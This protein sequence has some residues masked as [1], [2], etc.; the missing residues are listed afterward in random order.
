M[1]LCFQ[2]LGDRDER[3]NGQA[4]HPDLRE[5]GSVRDRVSKQEDAW[6]KCL[7]GTCGFH[8]PTTTHAGT[9][10]SKCVCMPMKYISETLDLIFVIVEMF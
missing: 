2:W 5:P 6:R 1:R 3:T 4:G 8:M 7:A 9:H 10:L